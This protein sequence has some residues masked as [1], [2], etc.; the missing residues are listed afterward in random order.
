MHVHTHACPQPWGGRGL[1]PWEALDVVV[2]GGAEGPALSPCTAGGLP[3]R[4]QAACLL[5]APGAALEKAVIRGRGPVWYVQSANAKPGICARHPQSSVQ[6]CGRCRGRLGPWQSAPP[7]P[8]PRRQRKHTHLYSK[9][10]SESR[11]LNKGSEINTRTDKAVGRGG[12]SGSRRSEGAV[13]T[14]RRRPGG[15]PRSA[16]AGRQ[17]QGP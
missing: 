5:R 11:A 13:Q 12:I 10:I 1:T 6:T 2:S 3:G 8:D 17:A 14:V 16:P 9:F 15:P 4:G 7:P